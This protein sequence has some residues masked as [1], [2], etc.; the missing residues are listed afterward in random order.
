MYGTSRWLGIE[1]RSELN[2]NPTDGYS[3]LRSYIN[4]HLFGKETREGER[5]EDTIS[6]QRFFPPLSR[7][8]SPPIF[9]SPLRSPG[10]SLRA[11]ASLRMEGRRRPDARGTPP[12]R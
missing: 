1:V 8:L 12:N 2:V 3:A 6:A 5:R 10:S 9:R 4:V 11:K 7:T